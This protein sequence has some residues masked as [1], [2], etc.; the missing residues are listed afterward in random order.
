MK[1]FKAGTYV[2]Q[3]YYKS[4]QPNPINREWQIE[5]ME[6]VSLL[7]KADR[8]LGRLEYVF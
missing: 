7:S 2:N 3:G 4:F 5:D 1:N 8:Q 6:L